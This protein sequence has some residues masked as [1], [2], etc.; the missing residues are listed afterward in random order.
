VGSIMLV[1]TGTGPP[2]AAG[3]TEEPEGRDWMREAI[4]ELIIDRH[5][6]RPSRSASRLYK[7][8]HSKANKHIK[9][10]KHENKLT[11]DG[12]RQRASIHTTILWGNEFQD[13]V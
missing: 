10:N 12:V 2:L 4:S 7:A 1:G 3:D 5:W 11:E 8:Q 13:T 6:M 9:E